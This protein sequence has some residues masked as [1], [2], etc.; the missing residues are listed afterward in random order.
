VDAQQVVE[1]LADFGFSQYEARA[2]IGLVGQS[3]MTGYALSNLTGIPQPK[4]YETLR[5]LEEKRAV[6]R[7]GSNPARFV[8]VPPD[9]LMSAIGDRYRKRL[10]DVQGGLNALTPGGQMGLRVLDA[11]ASWEAIR[12][13]AVAL[14]A[15][16]ER[17]IYLSVHADQFPEIADAVA[18]ADERGI[19]CDV[20]C[21]GQA[22]LTLANGRI[23]EHASTDG[24]IYRHHQARHLAVV[25]DS[26]H[27][28]WA[29][30]TDGR[31]WES[32]AGEDALLAAAVKGYVRHDLYVQQIFAD[33]GAEMVARY[34]PA[35]ES[36]V[37]P[38]IVDNHRLAV[39]KPAA[40]RA[41]KQPRSA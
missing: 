38:P 35:L 41:R 1:G 4:V 6:V 34:G 24:V 22:S 36:L 17:H 12:D 10:D 13:R 18:A 16:G 25:A 33:F 9:Q 37:V 39:S 20:L 3:S 23:V 2:Y 15:A 26:V 21:F 29:L 5:R 7:T 14:L 31:Q 28:L 27:A 32:M 19:R 8:A 11:P 30:A 40:K